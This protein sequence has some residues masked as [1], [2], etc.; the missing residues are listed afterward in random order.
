MNEQNSQ[1]VVALA[2]VAVLGALGAGLIVAGLY[3]KD[4]GPVWGG[5]GAIIGA[6]ATALNAPNGN[7]QTPPP[8]VFD[9]G[10]P[11]PPPD[12]NA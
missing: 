4:T 6:L 7:R 3:L 1:T 11:T 8:R 5:V 2:I 12:P 9:A 10:A